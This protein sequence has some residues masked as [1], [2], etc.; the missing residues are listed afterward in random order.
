MPVS[1]FRTELPNLEDV[2][3]TLTGRSIR[4]LAHLTWLG[5]FGSVAVPVLLFI[6]VGRIAAGSVGTASPAEAGGAAAPG[7]AAI[8]RTDLPRSSPH[9]LRLRILTDVG[10]RRVT[11]AEIGC[12]RCCDV[13]RLRSNFGS[14]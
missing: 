2:L 7:D 1:E 3:L 13:P 11:A 5:V 9:V 4:H 12:S 10:G 14:A 8:L 6:V